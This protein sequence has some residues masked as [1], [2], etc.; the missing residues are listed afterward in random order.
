MN[1]IMSLDQG[2]VQVYTGD[3]KGKTTAALGLA[4]RAS[5]AG[6]SVIIIQF[7]KGRRYSEIDAIERCKN[8]TIQQFGRDEFVSKKNPEQVDID[9]AQKGVQHAEKIIS[10]G[11]FDVVILDEIN[12]AVDYNLIRV[13]QVLHL[14]NIKPKHTELILTGR[15]AHA[16]IIKSADL[17]SEILDIRH[18][19]KKG[20]LSRK[21]IDW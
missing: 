14:I 18:P 6:L 2:Y 10:E 21:G 20:V 9:F 19:Y 5:G 8:I 16:E 7:M 4:L 3:G 1:T 11:T 17:V 15:Y 13:E 12:V